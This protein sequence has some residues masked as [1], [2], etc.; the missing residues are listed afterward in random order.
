MICHRKESKLIIIQY[1]F[2]IRINKKSNLISN[3]INKKTRLAF[4]IIARAIFCILLIK[5]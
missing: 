5:I 1:N 4:I 2:N 3:I